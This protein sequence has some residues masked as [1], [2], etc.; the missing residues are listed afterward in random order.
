[1]ISTS[2]K[3][4]SYKAIESGYTDLTFNSTCT[5]TETQLMV[6]RQRIATIK[7]IIDTK[8]T[9]KSKIDLIRGVLV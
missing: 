7:E 1:M 5:H 9:A 3:E 6:L 2:L 4:R 8:A